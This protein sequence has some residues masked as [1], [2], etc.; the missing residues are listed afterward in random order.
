MN[1]KINKPII[2]LIIIVSAI[3]IINRSNQDEIDPGAAKIM[4][5]EILGHI[6]YLASDNLKGR[7]PG[8]PGSK[9]AIDYIRKHWEAQG[10]EPAGTKGYKQSFSFINSVS[11]GQRNMLRIRNSRKRYI[12]QKDFIPIG[13]SGNGSVNEDVVFIGYGF[14]INDS[15][16]WRDYA[17]VDVRGKWVLLLLDGPDGDSPH[18]PYGRHK[19]LY[20]KII[21]ARDHG[22]SGILFM[23]RLEPADDNNLR[24]LQ[25]RQSSSTVGLPVI[26]ITHSVANEILKTH[27]QS[28]AELRS[29]LD[30]RLRPLSFQVDCKVSANV[31]LKF[32]KETASNMIGF[33]DGNDPV[34]KDEYIIVGAHF[35][36][37]GLGGRRSGS[38]DPDTLI[39]HNGADDNASGTAGILELS[40]KLMSNRHLL[41]R[42]VLTV[43]FDAEEKGLLGSKYYSE[44]PVRDISNTAMM[45]NMDMIGR[46][47]NNPVILGG[48][49]SSGIFENIIADA[50]KNHTLDIE[51]NMGG[52]DFARSD[53]ASFYRENIP[54]LFF[55]TGAHEDYHKPTDDWDKIDYQGEKEVLD[56]IY[57]LIIDVSQLE[58]KPAFAEIETNATNDQNPVFKVTF[59][60]IPA[61]GSQKVGLEID[62][63][64]KKDG[65]AAKAGMKKGDV[66][67]AIDGKD[68]RNIYDYMARLADLKPGQKVKVTINRGEDNIELILEL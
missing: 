12:V 23:N 45:I 59:G 57:E 48:V 6:K 8:T 29:K 62:G 19:T 5:F 24:P 3:F 2:V 14:D 7:L 22:V 28:I 16:S 47:N 43:C 64:S 1:Q 41:K 58:E 21:T 33:I 26:Q 54:V 68:V 37:L 46:L 42:S 55:F 66:I 53:H 27:G 40:H 34:L 31:N 38:L 63:V 52:M 15:L 67:T 17:D 36:H 49:G 50:R 56:F 61:Y 60:V 44:N 4:S 11:L 25:Y 32:D 65:P 9:L 10:I 51:T 20:N 39:I 18:S 30:E 35:D 13:S